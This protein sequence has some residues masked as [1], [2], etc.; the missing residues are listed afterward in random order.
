[1]TEDT[2]I[3]LLIST[4]LD[5]SERATFR[6]GSKVAHTCNRYMKDTVPECGRSYVRSALLY[7][8]NSD[9]PQGVHNLVDELNHNNYVEYV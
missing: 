6:D 9:G 3:N 2:F 1:M 5:Q 7:I 8:L 4:V